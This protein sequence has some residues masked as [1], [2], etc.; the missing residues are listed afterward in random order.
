MIQRYLLLLFFLAI[1][2][3]GEA[4][5]FNKILFKDKKICSFSKPRD[6]IFYRV[7]SKVQQMFFIDQITSIKVTEDCERS[8]FLAGLYHS[9]LEIDYTENHALQVF[10]TIVIQS[11]RSYKS[12]LW[13][14]NKPGKIYGLSKAKNSII[15]ISMNSCANY[16]DFEKVV[17]T[18]RKQKYFDRILVVECGADPGSAQVYW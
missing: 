4:Q 10:D 9:I 14:Y 5:N 15:L 1:V 2:Q 11:H 6:S 7:E 3:L 8:S 16:P 12:P 17:N 18:I 13:N